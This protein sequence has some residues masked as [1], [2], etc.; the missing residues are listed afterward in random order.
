MLSTE[1]AKIYSFV[2]LVY[3]DNRMLPIM[4]FVTGFIIKKVRDKH[5]KQHF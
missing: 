1:K 5:Q 4:D 2:F 3:V